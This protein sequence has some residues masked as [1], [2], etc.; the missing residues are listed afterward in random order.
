[1][2]RLFVVGF[3]LLVGCADVR[4]ESEL[5]QAEHE[6]KLKEI[7]ETDF[8]RI[9]RGYRLRIA[10]LEEEL[11]AASRLIREYDREKARQQRYQDA[12][13]RGSHYWEPRYPLLPSK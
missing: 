13:E 1:M 11:A 5:I 2:K 10:E 3:V 8:E 7:S 6:R 9:E 4:R 12:A